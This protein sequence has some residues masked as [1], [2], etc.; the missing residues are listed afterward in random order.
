MEMALPSVLRG[1]HLAE[2][3]RQ[4]KRE[5][6][7]GHELPKAPR[8]IGGRGREREHAPAMGRRTHSVLKATK[9][10]CFHCKKGGLA[11]DLDGKIRAG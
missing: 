5:D 10:E 7:V 9:R 1:V 11:R 8:G 2:G 4:G 6:E 3:G